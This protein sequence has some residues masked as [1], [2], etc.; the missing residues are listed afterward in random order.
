VS[1]P[2][3]HFDPGR[4]NLSFFQACCDFRS[5]GKLAVGS[6]YPIPGK[7]YGRKRWVAPGSCQADRCPRPTSWGCR[8]GQNSGQ[9]R[10]ACVDAERIPG[11]LNLVI[12][13]SPALIFLLGADLVDVAG[14]S[15]DRFGSSPVL[16]TRSSSYAG[17]SGQ[18][19]GRCFDAIPRLLPDGGPI[20]LMR[21]NILLSL[22]SLRPGCTDSRE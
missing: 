6:L 22:L 12:S 3:K 11:G 15:P 14:R 5:N 18:D 16:K 9:A 8:N 10:A 4:W 2:V 17:L 19:L 1:I 13:P 7:V 20:I 21:Q